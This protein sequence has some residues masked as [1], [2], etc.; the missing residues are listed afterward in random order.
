M[1]KSN[2]SFQFANA[3]SKPPTQFLGSRRW[4]W[5]PPPEDVG[6]GESGFIAL[7]A[8]NEQFSLLKLSSSSMIICFD[9]HSTLQNALSPLTDSNQNQNQTHL[10]NINPCRVIRKKFI[11]VWLVLRWLTCTCRYLSLEEASFYRENN[12]RE[13]QN[14][15]ENYHGGD[16]R[17]WRWPWRRIC[18]RLETVWD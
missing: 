18:W 16:Q 8:M 9:L 12:V 11:Y 3:F 15:D 2:H 7:T 10:R 13:T 6:A 4:R 1:E 17:R 5:W 14:P